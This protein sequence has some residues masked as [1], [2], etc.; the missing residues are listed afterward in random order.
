MTLRYAS[1]FIGI[2][3]SIS[4]YA[5]CPIDAADLADGGSFSGPCVVDYGSTLTITGD[6]IWTGGTMEIQ[7]M[8]QTGGLN[9]SGTGSLT[10]QAGTFTLN[11]DAGFDDS[12]LTVA[13]G[14]SLTVESGAD[15]NV[16]TNIAIAGSATIDGS[17]DVTNAG[18]VTVT[19][20]L[21]VSGSMAIAA[22]G[23]SDGTGDLVADGGTVTVQNGGFID[24]GDDAKAIN[25]GVIRVESGGQMDVADKLL[26][27]PF[28]DP[29]FNSPSP[30][31][32]VVSG[33]VNVGGEAFIFDT[34]PDSGIS[35]FG[36]LTVT[37]T[38]TN[39]ESSFSGETCG[40][41]ATC[42][43]GTIPLPVELMSFTSAEKRSGILL[44][45]STATETNNEG[46][47]VERSF[48]GV[49]FHTIGFVGGNGTTN[50]IQHYSFTDKNVSRNRF[51]R[52]KQV[53][54][55]GTSEYHSIIYQEVV[56]SLSLTIYPNPVV[57]KINLRGSSNELS[58][59]SLLDISGKI[60]FHD[61]SN[62]LIQMEA[63]LNKVIPG[64]VS[65]KTYLLRMITID[66]K[67]M[68]SKIYKK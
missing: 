35:G 29:A 34:T 2:L 54:Y 9:I 6:V 7:E 4:V 64:L 43:G 18:T 12:E 14:G 22:A 30:G 19:G 61:T 38:F 41:G 26:N 53:D 52:L 58:E 24:V 37:G 11:A 67:V 55:D 44:D 46:F 28:G 15:L 63:N 48:D 51:Y 33:T 40:G 66:G 27:S 68:D 31:S 13:S 42:S 47:Y 8:W 60:L 57:D 10:I 39:N 45:W 23:P 56:Q 65:S 21:D 59:I 5:Q 25:S 20:T 16:E 49:E 3:L 50:E 62:E 32:F 1:L 36:T 17:M